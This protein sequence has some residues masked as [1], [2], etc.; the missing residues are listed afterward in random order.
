MIESMS[1]LTR[2]LPAIVHI[3]RRYGHVG[4][5]ESYVWELTKGLAARGVQIIVVCEEVCSEITP[6]ITVLTVPVSRPRPRWKSMKSFRAHVAA[7][8]AS[9]ELDGSIIHSHER[10]GG[11][12]V[13]TFHGPPIVASP[14][15]SVW[16]LLSRRVRQWRK[17]ESEELLGKSVQAVLPVSSWVLNRLISCYPELSGRFTRVAWPGVH[18]PASALE[19]GSRSVSNRFLFVGKE[20]ARK[21]LADAVRI[22]DAYCRLSGVNATLDVV[23]PS[24]QELPKEIRGAN[25]VHAVGWLQQI[26]YAGYSALI[27]PAKAEP[28]GMVVTEARRVGLPVICS[29]QTGAGEIESVGVLVVPLDQSPEVWAS[30]LVNLLARDMAKEP[31]VEWS[32]SDLV[33]LHIREIYPKIRI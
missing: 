32:W 13:T 12:H 25:F 1:V 21:G 11:H 9:G 29:D 33:D 30:G 26:D 20:F 3:V 2:S 27:H 4:G 10:T 24:I 5:M 23:G 7:L 31:E 17:M 22:V 28:F 8:I 15:L 18:P 6:D 19:I 16:Q 14:R